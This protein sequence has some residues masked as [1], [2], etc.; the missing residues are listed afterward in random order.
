MTKF[1]VGDVVIYNGDVTKFVIME[2]VFGKKEVRGNWIYGN[3]VPIIDSYVVLDPI[4]NKNYCF[5]ISTE[6]CYYISSPTTYSATI[7][8]N[9]PTSCPR[10]KEELIEKFSEYTNSTI[11]KCPKCNWC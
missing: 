7:K 9:L 5:P 1:K 8:Q 4:N 3:V 11:L 6:D 10:C 2:I